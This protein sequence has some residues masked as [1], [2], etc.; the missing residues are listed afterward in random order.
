MIFLNYLCHV[1]QY[2]SYKLVV[3]ACVAHKNIVIMPAVTNY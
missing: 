1:T 2:S 3:K